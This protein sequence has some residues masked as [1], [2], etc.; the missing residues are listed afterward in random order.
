MEFALRASEMAPLRP[1]NLRNRMN[2]RANPLS[3][4][5]FVSPLPQKVFCEIL[6]G[7]PVS[8]LAHI[9]CANMGKHLILEVLQRVEKPFSTRWQTAEK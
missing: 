6:F 1:N 4:A 8:L 2:L 3:V 7:V 9:C 5:S